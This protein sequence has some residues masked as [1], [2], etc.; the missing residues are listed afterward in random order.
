MIYIDR[1]SIAKPKVFYSKE[2]EYAVENLNRFYEGSKASRTQK[3]YS[4][5]FEP[6]LRKPIIDALSELFKMKC[7]YCEAKVDQANSAVYDHFRPKHGARWQGSEFANEHYWWLTYEWRNFYFSCQKCN[8]FKA[9]WFPIEGKRAEINDSYENVISKEKQLLIDPCNENPREHFH[10]SNQGE[11]YGRTKRGEITVDF[12]KLNRKDLIKS[13]LEVLK[14]VYGTWELLLKLWND[15]EGNW[16]EIKKIGHE[17]GDILKEKSNQPFIAAS[18]QLIEDRLDQHSEIKAFFDMKLYE[19]TRETVSIGL[20]SIVEPLT[21]DLIEEEKIKKPKFYGGGEAIPIEDLQEP[22]ISTNQVYL[23][24]LELKNFKCFDE[25]KIQFAKE[26]SDN[27]DGFQPWLLFLGENGVGKSSVLKAISIALMPTTYRTKL[28]E[29]LTPQKLLKYGEDKGYIKLKYNGGEEILV[30]F[31]KKSKT[32]KSSV[33][34]SLTNVMG[35]GSV[36]LLPKVSK[37]IK[38]E[39]GIF[40]GVKVENLFDYTTSVKNADDWLLKKPKIQFDR[41]AT[42]LKDLM[43]LSENA[44]LKRDKKNK[45]IFI[46]DELRERMTV[47]ELSDGYKTIYALAVDIMA[48]LSSEEIDYDLV[49][50]IVLIDEIGTHLHPRWKMQVVESLRTAFPKLQFIVSTHEPL[51]L[52]GLNAGETIVLSKN[53]DDRII[54]IQD[55]PDPSELRIDQILT[56]EFFGLKSTF[57]P[58]TEKLFE[59]YYAILA[60]DYLNRSDSEKSRLQELQKIIPRVKHLG[61]NLREDLAYYVVDELLAKKVKEDGGLKLDKSIKKEALDRVASLWNSIKSD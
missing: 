42:A 61:D 2:M 55:L 11:V 28:K 38:P 12:L 52:R 59:E 36:R 16:K 8:Q 5:S 49:E 29:H 1:E 21:R 33:S 15:K 40:N 35:Y 24:S 4:K 34:E 50:G 47:E 3:R 43:Q 7:A 48:T 25:L 18:K 17:W 41:A 39:G 30:N 19:T 53:N 20:R 60:K 58:K 27:L 31:D 10:F 46:D 56:S 22:I 44:L 37:G 51:C 45:K 23:E 6:E 26:S 32:I 54:A 57:D 13:R 14:E 9:S